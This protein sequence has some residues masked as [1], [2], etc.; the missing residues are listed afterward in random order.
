MAANR[1]FC[2]NDFW[3]FSFLA[4]AFSSSSAEM[5]I[6][7]G[8]SSTTAGVVATLPRLGAGKAA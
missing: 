5:T 2:L 7:A 4:R 8:I 1:C 6:Q 3:S